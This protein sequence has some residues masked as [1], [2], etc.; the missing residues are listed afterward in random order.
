MKSNPAAIRECLQGDCNEILKQSMHMI[1]GDRETATLNV[2]AIDVDAVLQAPLKKIDYGRFA[3]VPKT[4][5]V[6][7]RSPKAVSSRGFV[8]T[9]FNK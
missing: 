5:M 7:P 4:N 2:C 8:A 1:D 9:L 6:I 3:E